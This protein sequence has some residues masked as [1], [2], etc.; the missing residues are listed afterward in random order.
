MMVTAAKNTTPEDEMIAEATTTEQS[1]TS[2]DKIAHA[3]CPFCFVA[4]APGDPVMALCGEIITFKGT[5]SEGTDCPMCMDVAQTVMVD[6]AC[7]Y[8]P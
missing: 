3:G 1:T 7:R 5:S 2:P 6:R 8:C 4:P